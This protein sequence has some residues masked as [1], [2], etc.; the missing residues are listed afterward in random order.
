MCGADPDNSFPTTL[1]HKVHPRVHG[2][3]Y[4]NAYYKTIREWLILV[5]TE[6]IEPRSAVGTD[7]TVHP[8]AYGT[9]D[10]TPEAKDAFADSSPCVRGRS[11]NDFHLLTFIGFIP[12]RT[13]ADTK[14][15][16]QIPVVSKP[17]FV[18]D[19]C[20]KTSMYHFE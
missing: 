6:Q 15:L 3:E 13:G 2:V 5:H 16:K 11:K 8:R 10:M 18:L 14:F 12:V 4:V 20:N 17:F 9:D 1:V 7:V 19:F